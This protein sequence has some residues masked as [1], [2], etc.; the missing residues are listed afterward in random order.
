MDTD[1]SSLIMDSCFESA[2]LEMA[3]DTP[4]FCDI[5]TQSDCSWCPYLNGKDAIERGQ[6]WTP[7]MVMESHGDDHAW[8]ES[9]VVMDTNS[10]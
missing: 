7:P 4:C 2:I 8:T 5:G 9:C 6:V 3:R 10:E 1:L